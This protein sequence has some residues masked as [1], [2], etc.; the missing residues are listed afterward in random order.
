MFVFDVL[1]LFDLIVRLII[2]NR[3]DAIPDEPGN[4]AAREFLRT[5]PSKGL[6]MPLGKEVKV[7]QCWRWFVR[8]FKKRESCF[9][10]MFFH[11]VFV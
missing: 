8:F 1:C 7:M 6:H 2:A 3:Q 4:E 10:I 5:A 11:F 9:S